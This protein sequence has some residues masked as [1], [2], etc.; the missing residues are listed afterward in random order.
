MQCR[1]QR[2]MQM[3]QCKYDTI[4][5]VVINTL[6]KTE[7]RILNAEKR[8]QITQKVKKGERKLHNQQCTMLE[9]KEVVEQTTI[10]SARLHNIMQ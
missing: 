3:I 9:R 5:G 2:K 8:M 10:Q 1:L 6:L 7:R 4:I